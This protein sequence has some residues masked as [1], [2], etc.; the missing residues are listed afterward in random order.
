MLSQIAFGILASNRLPSESD[1]YAT[2]FRQHR[3]GRRSAPLDRVRARSALLDS[4]DVWGLT[5]AEGRAGAD[6]LV[7]HFAP[8]FGAFC[9]MSLCTVR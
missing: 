3:C 8:F 1:G 2:M 9:A 7:G 4:A 5:V 6:F